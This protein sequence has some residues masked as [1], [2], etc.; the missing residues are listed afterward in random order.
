MPIT[1]LIVDDDLAFRKAVKRLLESA[2]EV[3]VVGEARMAKRP[4]DLPKS[5]ALIWS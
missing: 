1:T 3:S 4:F 5:S 2:P